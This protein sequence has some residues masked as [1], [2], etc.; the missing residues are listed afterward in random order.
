[1]KSETNELRTLLAEAAAALAELHEQALKVKPALDKPTRPDDPD[2]SWTPWNRHLEGPVS[3]AQRLAAEIRNRL[4]A[5]PALGVRED[6][7]A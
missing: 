7:E 3:N 6:G 5:G 4:N 1:L 2:P